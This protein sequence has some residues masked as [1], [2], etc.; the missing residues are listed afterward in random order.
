MPSFRR[1]AIACALP[2]VAA[3]L[4]A[5]PRTVA[6]Q[7]REVDLELVL[8]A[9]I[10]GSMDQEEAY[11]QREGFVQALRHPEVLEAILS[12]PLGRISVTY[13]EWAGEPHQHTLVDWT[14]ITD[15]ESAAAFADAVERPA[16]TRAMYT[17][18]SSVI[19]Y[20]ARRFDGNGFRAPRQVIDISGDGPNNN[21]EYVVHARDRAVADGI[22]INGLPIINGRPG[23]Y[24]LAPLPDLDLYYEDCV[25]GGFGA[26]VVVANGFADFARAI[27]RKML[28]EIAGTPLPTRFIRAAAGGTRPPCNAGEMQLHQWMDND[29]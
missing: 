5:T 8:A 22:V 12:G 19:S 2:L 13:V 14:E 6:A 4:A 23:P 26:F 7:E 28:M 29:Y 15:A 25:I 11:L 21:G 16:V 24:G 10:S 17:S 18:I 9:D 3:C 27:R 20:A 1:L